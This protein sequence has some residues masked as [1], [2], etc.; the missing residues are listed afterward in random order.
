[1]PVSYLVSISF[2]VQQLPLG[3]SMAIVSSMAT[4]FVLVMLVIT[5]LSAKAQISGDECQPWV[6]PVTTHPDN[7]VVRPGDSLNA[8]D[9]RRV[10]WP[11]N[12]YQIIS[13]NGNSVVIDIDS[14]PAPFADITNRQFPEIVDP[15]FL[16]PDLGWELI[17]IH[18]GIGPSG[19]RRYRTPCVTALFYNRYSGI[20]R[21]LFYFTETHKR[22]F[23]LASCQMTVINDE[24][25]TP[26]FIVSN[27]LNEEALDSNIFIDI[28][29]TR[30]RPTAVPLGIEDRAWVYEDFPTAYDPCACNQSTSVFFNNVW[31]STESMVRNDSTFTI[32]HGPYLY[33]SIGTFT[34][35]SRKDLRSPNLPSHVPFYDAP[36]GSWNLL[37][38]PRIQLLQDDDVSIN[39]GRHTVAGHLL[40]QEPL[41]QTIND[42]VFRTDVPVSNTMAYILTIHGS[43]GDM[44]GLIRVND[45]LYVTNDIDA[46]CATSRSYRFSFVPSGTYAI[47]S[48]RL[49]LRP[50]LHP[51][52]DDGV[53]VIHPGK[54]FASIL[55]HTDALRSSE[56]CDGIVRPTAEMLAAFCSSSTYMNR[57]KPRRAN[58]PSTDTIVLQPAG[59]EVL[60]AYPN[61]AQE[62]TTI[63]FPNSI[64][65]HIDKIWLVDLSGRTVANIDLDP[66]M[67]TSSAF[68]FRTAEIAAGTYHLIVRT[69]L[70]TLGT[71]LVIGR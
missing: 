44:T 10:V 27:T 15:D 43:I 53:D 42:H 58:L 48:A 68:T 2:H 4:P 16:N 19:D 37:R 28:K 65:E 12:T 55:I 47:T 1:M 64:G 62:A 33:S 69:S 60:L 57:S 32:T 23:T 6:L 50:R 54:Y 29:H 52:H 34:P 31:T 8:F 17:R 7:P 70:R 39:T 9:W 3:L 59:R 22:P 38:T 11:A 25:P 20:I 21:P 63:V 36:L 45:T 30:H 26:S 41:Q 66:T 51:R 18:D 56:H 46:D 13:R 61:P 35:G 40:L 5:S 49:A 14:I 67:S 71:M 24:G